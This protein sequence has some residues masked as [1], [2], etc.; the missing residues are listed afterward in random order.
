MTCRD[1]SVEQVKASFLQAAGIDYAVIEVPPLD[2]TELQE[3]QVAF[4]SL[5][6]PLAN[7]ALREILRN[8]YFIDKALQIPWDAGRPLPENERDFR[9]LFWRQIVDRK[10]TRLNSSHV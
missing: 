3:I 8:P 7:P 5:A 6:V 2:D 4:P 1:Y 10:S 9:R